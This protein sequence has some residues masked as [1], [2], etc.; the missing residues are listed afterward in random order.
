MAYEARLRRIEKLVGIKRTPSYVY[1]CTA[2]NLMEEAIFL[3]K[4]E[5]IMTREEKKRF[6]FIQ[7]RRRFQSGIRREKSL[8]NKSNKKKSE[9][10]NG[11]NSS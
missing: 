11:S 4:F 2:D 6:K 10:H 3:R 5:N 8:K 9:V 7:L 1:S